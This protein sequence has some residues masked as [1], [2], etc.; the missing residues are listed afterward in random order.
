M[1]MLFTSGGITQT[2]CGQAS[3]SVLLSVKHLFLQP[4]ER[5]QKILNRLCPNPVSI[6]AHTHT[7]FFKQ[8]QVVLENEDEVAVFHPYRCLE[9]ECTFWSRRPRISRCERGL[10]LPLEVT[11]AV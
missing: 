1:S 5:E 10:V 3:D 6:C 11:A 2:D 8:G 7:G 4:A 9:Q